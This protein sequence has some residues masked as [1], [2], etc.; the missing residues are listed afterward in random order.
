M[1][2]LMVCGTAMM[3]AVATVFC[4]TGLHVLMDWR[5]HR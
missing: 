2:I 4:V 5:R 1:A 3:V